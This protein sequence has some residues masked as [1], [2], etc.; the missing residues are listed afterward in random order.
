MNIDSIILEA[1]GALPEAF[2]IEAD[3]AHRTVDPI[4]IEGAERMRALD[5]SSELDGEPF[6][7]PAPPDDA[8]LQA[9]FDVE[10]H[11][12]PTLRPLPGS[13]EV[14]SDADHEDASETEAIHRERGFEIFASYVSFRTV[15][16]EGKWG[17]FYRR[18]GIRRL[19]L[20]LMR[21]VKA[22]STEARRLAYSL[23]WAHERF[24]F[25]FDLGA[26]YDE[27]VLK[28]PL[29]NRYSQEVY[30]KVIFTSECFEESLANRAVSLLSIRGSQVSNSDLTQFV[31]EFCKNSPPGYCD[32]DRAPVVMKECL[33]GQLRS[34]KSSGRSNSPEREWLAS[35]TRQQCPE[36]F[37][38]SCT[39]SAGKFIKCKLGGYI[40]IVHP[41]DVDPWPSKPHAHN[42]DQ[43]QKLNL[44]SGE[45]FSLPA[46]KPVGKLRSEELL[47][48]RKEISL[49]LPNLALP[50]M[51]A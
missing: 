1:R 50:P 49:R 21:D 41:F 19:A 3:D 36:Y 48:I 39:F 34:G 32:Y 29:Y 47:S 9:A 18:E 2:T 10:R 7:F 11:Y 43:R 16:P 6:E 8:L 13:F 17:I 51:A 23:L 22:D 33:L 4:E 35:L 5:V 45:I 30:K 26:L 27:L 38:G 24:H 31:K 20:L 40:W 12:D 15:H 25:R 14:F 42:Y 46:R 37:I 44:S 28:A